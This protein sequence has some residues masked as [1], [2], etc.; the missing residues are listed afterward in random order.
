MALQAC[1]QPGLEADPVCVR[2]SISFAN[3][4]FPTGPIGGSCCALVQAGESWL[5]QSRTRAYAFDAVRFYLRIWALRVIATSTSLILPR[6][7]LPVHARCS[8]LQ[9]VRARTCRSACM[10]LSL[11]TRSKFL[12]TARD[13][14]GAMPSQDGTQS[15]L[16]PAGTAHCNPRQRRPSLACGE[17]SVTPVW[18]VSGNRTTGVDACRFVH[19]PS[20]RF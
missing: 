15:G 13:M 3:V 19:L 8:A 1:Q 9:Q 7:R 17:S 12:R 14:F 6:F 5:S 4:R 16:R 11:P 20:L 2:A 18:R 10:I